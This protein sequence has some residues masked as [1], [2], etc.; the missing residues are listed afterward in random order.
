M[1]WGDGKGGGKQKRGGDKGKDANFDRGF[2]PPART[3]DPGQP[4][5]IPLYDAPNA[6]APAPKPG[7]WGGNA[8]QAAQI[9]LNPPFSALPIYRH[10]AEIKHASLVQNVFCVQ[11]ETGCGKSSVVPMLLLEAARETGGSEV[12]DWQAR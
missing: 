6:P 11:G 4:S 5:K 2:Q 9:D 3:L 1:G 8:P 10:A 12:G 7:A